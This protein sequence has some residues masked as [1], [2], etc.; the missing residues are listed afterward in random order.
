ME[1]TIK[2]ANDRA[3]TWVAYFPDLGEWLPTIYHGPATEME[4]LLAV[5]GRNPGSRV[6]SEAT[7]TWMEESV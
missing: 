4:V 7:G 5:S 3:G 1:I 6:V 2:R